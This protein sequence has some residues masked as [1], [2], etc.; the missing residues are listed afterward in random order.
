MSLSLSLKPTL[1]PSGE[2][3]EM[4]RPTVMQIAIQLLSGEK[5]SERMATKNAVEYAFK[6]ADKIKKVDRERRIR[7]IQ[8]TT[9]ETCPV[10]LARHPIYDDLNE[11]K[12]G[13]I[14]EIRKE[15]KN[16]LLQDGKA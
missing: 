4:E 6:I 9:E 15:E 7:A 5:I 13:E 16:E 8:S 12:E 11:W 1:V 2:Y 10:S 14:R 3:D